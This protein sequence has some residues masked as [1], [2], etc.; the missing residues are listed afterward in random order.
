MTK[1]IETADEKTPIT[2][3]VKLMGEKRIGSVI[4]TS[5][6]KPSGIFT[7]RDLLTSI[8]LKGEP[9]SL[10]VGK[11]ASSPLITIPSGTSV[12]RAAHSMASKHIRRLPVAKGGKLEGIV[13][14][15]DLVE[16]YAK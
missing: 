15:R 5:K 8:L 9:L 7:E 3:S 16:A 10:E 11:V 12:H 1:E 2:H 6:G 13:T 4:V 14:A